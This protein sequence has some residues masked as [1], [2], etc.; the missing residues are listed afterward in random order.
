[1]WFTEGIRMCG[2]SSSGLSKQQNRHLSHHKNQG[3]IFKKSRGRIDL[4]YHKR[5]RTF[6]VFENILILKRGLKK[7]NF[8]I[9]H[10]HY[11]LSTF[12]ASLAGAKLLVVSLMGVGAINGNKKGNVI[13]EIFYGNC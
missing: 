1:M 11:S 2:T 6:R 3:G 8:D 5:E 13:M 9:V 7:Y 4:F 12:V 10:A